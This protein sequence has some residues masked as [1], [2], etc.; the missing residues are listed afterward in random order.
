MTL[1]GIQLKWNIL[2]RD[3]IIYSFSVGVLVLVMWDGLVTWYEST[4]LL[5][6]FASYF[7]LLFVND[8]IVRIFKKIFFR[9][10]VKP[11]DPETTDTKAGKKKEIIISPLNLIYLYINNC[12]KI[13]L[14]CNIPIILKRCL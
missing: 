6:L 5:L 4:I 12:T 14:A 1:Q 10:E 7:T 9:S 13:C 2:S 11:T 3:C 8:S